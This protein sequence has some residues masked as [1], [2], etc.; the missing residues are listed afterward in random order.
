MI[1]DKIRFEDGR[2]VPIVDLKENPD[3]RYVIKYIDCFI[4]GDMDFEVVKD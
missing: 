3:G 1:G 2:V 4:E